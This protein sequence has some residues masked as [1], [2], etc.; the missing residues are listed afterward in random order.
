MIGGAGGPERSGGG[1]RGEELEVAGR[2]EAE[3]GGGVR[4]GSCLPDGYVAVGYGGDEGSGGGRV[5]NEGE[6]E[7]VAR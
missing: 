7:G 5:C 2:E 6:G 4:R 1:G 3:N